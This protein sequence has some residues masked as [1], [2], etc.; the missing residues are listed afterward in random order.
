MSGVNEGDIG[1]DVGT[2]HPTTNDHVGVNDWTILNDKNE[3][4]NVLNI[5]MDRW[6]YDICYMYT[7]EKWTI[8]SLSI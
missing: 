1:I 3:W 4:S 6:T 5:G 8:W 2:T 7:K